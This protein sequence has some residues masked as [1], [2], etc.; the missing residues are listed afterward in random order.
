MNGLVSILSY[1]HLEG[2][3]SV[4]VQLCRLI[5]GS[6]IIARPAEH[7]SRGPEEVYDGGVGSRHGL[8]HALVGQL[9]PTL[10][11]KHLQK[12]SPIIINNGKLVSYISS[13]IIHNR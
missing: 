8:G 6:T 4:I 1:S 7:E 11:V 9:P 12:T 3:I 2:T 5:V 10:Q 13:I